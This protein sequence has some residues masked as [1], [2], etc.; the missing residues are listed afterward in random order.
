[1][2]RIC[3][4]CPV[5]HLIASAKA[6][7]EILAVE[8][9]PTGADLRRV[10]NLAQI[11]QSHALSLLPPLVAGPAVR[12]RRRPG[13][14]QHLRR[15]R[16]TTRSSP[17]TAS[18]CA[19]SASRSSSGSAASGST[20]QGIVPG[21]V[22]APLT[23]EVRDRILAGVPEAHRGRRAGASTGTSPTCCAGR[24]RP[25]PSAT[26]ARRS[27]ASSTA[28]GNVDHYDGWLRVVDADGKLP[29]RPGRPEAVQRLHRRGRRAVV[30]PE[31]DLLEGDGLP[32]RPVPGR[33]AGPA[34][35]GR[36]A[37][38]R[39]GPTRSWTKFRWR[40]GRDRRLARSTTTTRG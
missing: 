35:R 26:S 27:W 8:P 34:Q 30:V 33:P 11:V 23:A 19:S 21:G 3:G 10:M 18:A 17:G 5:S 37:S 15:G 32:G 40:V 1:M 22:A 6:C 12:L 28:H 20:P 14:P 38:A 39:R 24:R 2:A 7:D 16:A 29:G 25:R 13:R 31:V 4:I 9:P 36:A